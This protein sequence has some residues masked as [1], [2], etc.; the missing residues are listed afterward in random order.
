MSFTEVFIPES[1]T[2]PGFIR[3]KS[4]ISPPSRPHKSHLPN[5]PAVWQEVIRDTP[6]RWSGSLIWGNKIL[7]RKRKDEE[8]EGV[9][10]EL[11]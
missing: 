3:L 4:L 10:E 5:K 1:V 6:R 9:G 8:K 7:L 11:G 2:Q